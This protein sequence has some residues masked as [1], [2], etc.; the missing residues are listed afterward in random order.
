MI[1][2]LII[3][4]FLHGTRGNGL[5]PGAESSSRSIQ[6]Q[7]AAGAGVSSIRTSPDVAGFKKFVFSFLDAISRNDTAFIRKHVQFPYHDSDNKM[8]GAASYLKHM[9]KFFPDSL[10]TDI[11][12]KG[13]FDYNATAARPYYFMTLEYDHDPDP[14]ETYRWFFWKK[15]D[16]FILYRD[17]Y[18]DL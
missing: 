17:T 10:S 5:G 16:D 18:E 9:K 1:I 13:E 14:T 3:F 7:A 4:S 2:I 11:R 12:K 8:I 15:G 6:V